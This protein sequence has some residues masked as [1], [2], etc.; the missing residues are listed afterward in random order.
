MSKVICSTNWDCENYK[1]VN[2]CLFVC[3][4]PNELDIEDQVTAENC[5]QLV[6]NE[7]TTESCKLRLKF[8]DEEKKEF[9][10]FSILSEAKCVEV[11]SGQH[12]EYNATLHSQLIE[13]AADIAM[14][15]CDFK[16]KSLT[17]TF[18]LTLISKE[19]KKR[20]WLFSI[21]V[22]LVDKRSI[23]EIDPFP[24]A[25]FSSFALAVNH[26]LS[27]EKL[28]ANLDL[29]SSSSSQTKREVTHLTNKDSH[30]SLG[31]LASTLNLSNLKLHCHQD[32]ERVPSLKNSSENSST[33]STC[34]NEVVS[35]YNELKNHLDNKFMELENKIEARLARIEDLL[36]N[37]ISD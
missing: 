23:N 16:F 15:R 35:M 33:C 1:T 9:E 10:G 4:S 3:H 29:N 18:V 30:L 12:D 37:R 11:H 26:L 27:D 2:D 19:A 17:D 32:S 28:K 6:S 22:K 36:R 14:Y 21:Q 7:G 13:D 31:L 20:I 5:V 34:F 8:N 25:D 24:K